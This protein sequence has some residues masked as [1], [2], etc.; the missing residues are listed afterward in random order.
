MRLPRRGKVR[1]KTPRKGFNSPGPAAQMMS[2]CE[3]K[4]EAKRLFYD[5]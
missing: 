5:L 2:D 4:A 1:R 3:R